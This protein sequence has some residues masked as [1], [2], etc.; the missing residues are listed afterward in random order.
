VLVDGV[1]AGWL[2]VGADGPR[3]T[4]PLSLGAG[5]HELRILADNLGRFNYGINLGERKGLLDT[6][7][8][9]G[10]EQDIS[11]G[12]AALWQEVQFAGEAVANVK[13][14]AVRADA[15][16][17]HLGRLAFAG[18]SIW[19]LRAIEV[20]PGR[21]HL[22]HITGDRNSGGFFVNG[23]AVERFSRHRS[24]GVLRADITSS[25]RPGVNVLAL[26][27]LEYAGAPWRASLISYNPAQPLHARWSFRAGVTPEAGGGGQEAGGPA[28]YRATFSRAAVGEA[29]S[30]RLRVGTLVKG[31]IWLN[32]YNVGR[33]W[34]I[35]P[36]EDYKLPLSWLA[37]EN[38]LLIFAEEGET[39]EVTLLT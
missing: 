16:D 6:L 21:R 36:Q 28:F 14:W 18:P 33:Y 37:D 35:G 27:I 19:L 10:Q 32:G 9:G 26:N 38:E 17:V 11:G 2:G 20:E 23:V 13:P 12:W 31:Q 25:L 34:Q 4:L 29:T 15:A 3:S 30:L 1:D 39:T 7:Y 22:I 8:L 5:R 24:G